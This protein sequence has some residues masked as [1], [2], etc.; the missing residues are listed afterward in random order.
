[1]GDLNAHIGTDTE[2]WKGVIGWHGVPGLNENGRYLLQLKIEGGT[3]FNKRRIYV[4]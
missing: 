1:M 4:I 3:L 2:T